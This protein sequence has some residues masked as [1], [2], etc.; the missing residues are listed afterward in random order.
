MDKVSKF[1]QRLTKKEFLETEKLIERIIAGDIAKLNVK[2]L[3]GTSH[4]FRVRKGGIRVIF[5]R[6][7]GIVRILEIERRGEQ[8]Y[9][10]LTK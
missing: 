2:K 7:D 1:L 9:R 8:T 6:K 4:L 10:H 3:K 5:Q